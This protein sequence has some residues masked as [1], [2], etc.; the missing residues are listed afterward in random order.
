MESP[1]IGEIR[2]RVAITT[3]A[4]LLELTYDG[5]FSYSLALCFVPGL[6]PIEINPDFGDMAKLRLIADVAD[7]LFDIPLDTTTH[8][9]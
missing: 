3:F 5:R 6:N 1:A 4:V 7:A 8:A 2:S 9:C